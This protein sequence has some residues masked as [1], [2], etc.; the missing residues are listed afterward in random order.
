MKRKWKNMKKWIALLLSLTLLALSPVSIAET[1]ER[2]ALRLDH[3]SGGA[4]GMEFI[5]VVV[6][7]GADILSL[8]PNQQV[9]DMALE[10]LTWDENGRILTADPLYEAE[11]LESNQVLNIQAF[12][13]EI[14]PTLRVR[15]VNERGEK[16]CWYIGVS[17]ENGD[18]LLLTAEEAGLTEERAFAFSDLSGLVFTFCSGVGAWATEMVIAEDGSFTGRFHDSDMGDTGETYPNGKVYGCLFEGQLE[19]GEWLNDTTLRLKMTALTQPEG[20]VPEAIE[21]GILYITADPYGLTGTDELL[22]Y[23]P[24]TPLDDLPEGYLMWTYFYEGRPEKLP[25]YGLYNEK[26]E[27]G[28]VGDVPY[29]TESGIRE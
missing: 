13:P 22:L 24:G 7:E 12:E 14:L 10:K 23:L 29:E 26:E 19:I 21:D 25:F 2:G 28:F 5:P 4:M 1:A 9:S 6:D 11:T 8:W 16:E 27:C 3:F 20:S 17:G 18:L 15:C